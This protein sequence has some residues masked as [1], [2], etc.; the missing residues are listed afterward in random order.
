MKI[1]EV[2]KKSGLS[3]HTLRYYEKIGLLNIKKDKSG[4]REYTESDLS[5]IDFIQKLK[6]TG[7]LIKDIVTY[8]DLLHE[9]DSTIQRRLDLLISHE[10]N[11]KNNIIKL[12]ENLTI[13]QNKIKFYKKML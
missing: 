5:W 13:L 9:G 12:T 1:K 4:H 3:L 8:S 7:M 6:S 11:V 10:S 2:S